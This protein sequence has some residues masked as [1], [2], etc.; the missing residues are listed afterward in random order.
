MSWLQSQ[1]T[2]IATPIRLNGPGPIMQC[3]NGSL[4]MQ[5]E[6]RASFDANDTRI[7]IPATTS[8]A[9]KLISN[10]FAIL[11]ARSLHFQRPSFLLADLSNT[12]SNDTLERTS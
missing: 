9:Y 8:K 5:L 7:Q 2:I 4:N 10:G 12:S 11:H 1:N 3:V 6:F